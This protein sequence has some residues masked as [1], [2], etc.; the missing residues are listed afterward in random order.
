MCGG[1]TFFHTRRSR[2]RLALGYFLW[3]DPMRSRRIFRW[4]D[5]EGHK[6]DVGLQAKQAMLAFG[7][8]GWTGLGLG[9]SRAKSG[10][11]PEHHTDFI[12]P[13]IG[14][15]LGLITTLA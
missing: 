8:G 10:F 6:L 14:E 15:E 7:S 9:N 3:R 4:L 13:I 1:F 2:G 11:L 5:V 12:F